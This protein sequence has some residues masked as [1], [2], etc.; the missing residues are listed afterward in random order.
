MSIYAARLI[1]VALMLGGMKFADAPLWAMLS[2]PLI[3]AYVAVPEKA[4]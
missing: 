2:L 3:F 4:R 1:L